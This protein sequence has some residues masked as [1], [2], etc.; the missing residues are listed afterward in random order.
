MLCQSDR[1]ARLGTETAFEVLAKARALEAQGKN[2]VH[3]EIGEPDFDTPEHI[4]Q[5]AIDGLRNNET[6][7]TP[8]P[9]IPKFREAVAAYF[10]KMHGIEFDSQYI[11]GAAGAKPLLYY[12]ITASV[13]PGEEVIYPNPGYPIY[14]SVAKFVRAVPVP[15]PMKEENDFRFDIEVLKEKITS[16]TKLLILNSPAN[17]T[18]GVLEKSDL[19]AVA[20][21]ALD[22]DFFILSDE[23]YARITYDGYVNQSIV[24]LPG[25]QERTILAE[26]FSKTY[27]MT[28]W[29]AGFGYIPPVLYEH[30][31]RLIINTTSCMPKFVQTACVAALEGPQD[32]VDK[33]VAEFKRRRDRIVEGL[34]QVP[35]FSCLKPKG[36]FYVFPNVRATGKTSKQLA[37]ELLYDGGVAALSGACFGTY[38]EGYLRFSYATSM[39][40][41]EEC[42]RRLNRYM[43]EHPP[44]DGEGQTKL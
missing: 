6:H 44:K 33:M 17:P 29:R 43:G 22:H 12:G 40:N 34:N 42:L 20:D 30:V 7:Y 15:L 11:V 16:K 39:S 31:N 10:T 8:A 14:E 21:L 5:A 18:G 26:G 4:R 27:A 2:I 23:P 36:A 3:M 24:S 28:G 25:M 38:G 19:K 1:M 37:D 9:G 35:G 41:I 32:D 13:N